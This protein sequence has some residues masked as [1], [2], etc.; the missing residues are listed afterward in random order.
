[1]RSDFILR[2][3]KY[4]G[5]SYRWVMDNNPRYVSWIKENKPEML[6]DKPKP[7]KEVKVTNL[8]EDDGKFK[9]PL[10]LNFDN[11]PPHEQCIPYMLD[12]PEQYVEQLMEF[13][14]HHKTRFR[15][16]KKEC[17]K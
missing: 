7:K 17:G 4:K 13:E 3:G 16:I 10:N 11:E 1:M 9:M 12:H 6:V 8:K 15:L 5:K 2:S 14:K